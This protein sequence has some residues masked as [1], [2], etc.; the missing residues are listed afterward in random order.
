MGRA[1]ALNRRNSPSLGFSPVLS[2]AKRCLRPKVGTNPAGQLAD[3]NAL[4]MTQRA[5]GFHQPDCFA[6]RSILRFIAGDT[7]FELSPS[8]VK[9][10]TFARRRV[11]RLVKMM[12]RGSTAPAMYASEHS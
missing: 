7:A 3:G 4:S 5:S 12:K 11:L 8:R 9:N 2:Y 6:G 10:E 1:L